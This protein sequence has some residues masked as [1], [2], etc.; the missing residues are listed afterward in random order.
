MSYLPPRPVQMRL[1]AVKKYRNGGLVNLTADDQI[2]VKK[3][4]GTRDE[5][6]KVYS[7]LDKPK[8]VMFEG[9]KKKVAKKKKKV[10]KK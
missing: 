6:V 5:P 1:N 8:P 10:V 4:N 2:I 9:E 3:T 7:T